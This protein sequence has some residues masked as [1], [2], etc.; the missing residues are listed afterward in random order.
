LITWGLGSSTEISEW[1]LTT[2]A[3]ELFVSADRPCA[4]LDMP[5]I[6]VPAEGQIPTF[7]DP[8]QPDGN[9]LATLDT[10]DLRC[11]DV[12]YAYSQVGKKLLSRTDFVKVIM[13][14]IK[15]RESNM[16]EWIN[17]QRLTPRYQNITNVDDVSS[18]GF[19]IYVPFALP[20]AVLED[21]QTRVVHDPKAQ[22]CRYLRVPGT[23][24][25][26]RVAFHSPGQVDVFVFWKAMRI[27][28][29]GIPDDGKTT[30]GRVAEAL[31]ALDLVNQLPSD[32]ASLRPVAGTRNG[33][34]PQTTAIH[35][36][37]DMVGFYCEN[38]GALGF[39]TE[40]N[41]TEEVGGYSGADRFCM[42]HERIRKDL[43]ER[44]S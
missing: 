7:S 26:I 40:A 17:V 5:D 4:A 33:G 22:Q 35:V 38:V 9:V 14:A 29:F 25:V 41:P 27:S 32:P 10:R 28:F 16:D 19:T 21:R 18:L 15:V 6:T 43:I 34:G 13:E 12:F 2:Q 1:L 3:N 8:Y 30:C 11:G 39:K 31:G 20:A 42:E 23:D 44:L 36:G 24:A 37:Y